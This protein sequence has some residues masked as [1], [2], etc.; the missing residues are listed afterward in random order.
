MRGTGVGWDSWLYRVFV[1]GSLL[2]VVVSVILAV[3]FDPAGRLALRVGGIEMAVFVVLLLAYWW[4]QIGLR[5]YG[6][7]RTPLPEGKPDV[8]DLT[9]LQSWSVLSSAMV[10]QA[11]DVEEMK[12]LER[13]SRTTL[14]IWF[15]WVTILV[16]FPVL[17]LG[18]PSALG[19]ITSSQFGFGVYFYMGF[20]ALTFILIIFLP[21]RAAKVNESILLT[22]LGLKLIQTPEA[23]LTP[24]LDNPRTAVR[25]ATVMEGSRHG[26]GVQITVES[27]VTTTILGGSAPSFVIQSQA[28]KLVAES[29]APR[30]VRQ[31]I[32][33]L[34][35]AKR[36]E[37]LELSGDAQGIRAT[38][39]SRG[40][41]MW[42]Y[43]LWL[44]ERILDA[45]QA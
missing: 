28:G 34:R 1:I 23:V 21:H 6:T 17:G 15:G 22:P 4:V 33:D 16:L 32:K 3:T 2:L 12:R 43:D 31:A 37:G 10:V 7:T 29:G 26:R 25:G 27:G 5:G 9:V 18:L 11:G 38:R 19:L 39:H 24:G 20:L 40:Q 41:N 44:S 42:L 14:L 36:W 45:A 13:A 35:R 8:N 30:A